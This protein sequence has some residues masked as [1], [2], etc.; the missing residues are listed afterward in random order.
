MASLG[1]ERT[2]PAAQGPRLCL[3]APGGTPVKKACNT[4]YCGLSSPSYCTSTLI[5]D[6]GMKQHKDEQQ[7]ALKAQAQALYQAFL[8][9]ESEDEVRQFLLDLPLSQPDVGIIYQLT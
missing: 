2:V 1:A 8:T 6:N 7:A 4:V 5:R 9:L 3:P